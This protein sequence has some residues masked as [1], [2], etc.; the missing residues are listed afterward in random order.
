MSCI[1]RG[2]RIVTTA[3]VAID[4]NGR[5]F[6]ARRQAGGAQS[7]RWEFPGGKCDEGDRDERLCLQREFR[8]EFEIDVDVSDEIGSIPFEH[9]GIRYILVA[10]H[11]RMHTEPQ[12]FTV[13]SEAG[14][15]EKD[16]LLE[17][18]L[19]DSDRSLIETC[20]TS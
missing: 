17:L 7:R 13:H 5:Y 16:H 19:A 14:W 1:Y 8:E 15:F 4:G 20:I 11:I 9:N 10:Y 18:D 3:G 12:V 2:D 6:L